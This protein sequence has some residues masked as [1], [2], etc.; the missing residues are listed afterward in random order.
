MIGLAGRGGIAREQAKARSRGGGGRRAAA[1][2]GMV[3]V[4]LAAAGITAVP[5]AAATLDERCIPTAW[6]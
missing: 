4:P 1:V 5:A 2:L 6:E 3:A